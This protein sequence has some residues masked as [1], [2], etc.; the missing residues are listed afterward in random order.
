[1]AVD[2]KMELSV[3][4]NHKSLYGLYLGEET[5]NISM[6]VGGYPSSLAIKLRVYLIHNKLV[7]YILVILN[8]E[9]RWMDGWMDTVKG[10]NN[11]CIR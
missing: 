1:M 2:P 6:G 9:N 10:K 7:Q 8:A 11:N 4:Y 5:N 3:S